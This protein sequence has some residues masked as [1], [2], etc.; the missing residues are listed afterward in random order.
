MDTEPKNSESETGGSEDALKFVAARMKNGVEKAKIVDEM[1]Q[2]GMDKRQAERLVDTAYRQVVQMVLKERVTGG[3]IQAGILGGLAAALI[4]GIA[5]AI[6]SILT[7]YELGIAAWGLGFLSGYAV[8]AFAG[9][10][11]GTALQI[12]AALA[13]VLAVVVGKYAAFAYYF[14]GEMAGGWDFNIFFD[15]QVVAAFFEAIPQIAGG[16]DLFWI[17]LAIAS[18]WKIPKG[19][20][21][22][23]PPQYQPPFV[24]G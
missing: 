13:A 4:G 15:G 18:A 16:F 12:I 20:G 14:S 17:L 1:A 7:G 2:G 5:W 19:L 24:T 6:V 23:L 8:V 21:I 3:A 9:G 22:D 10:R 11:K